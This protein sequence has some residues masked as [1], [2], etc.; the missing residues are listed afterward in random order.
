MSTYDEAPSVLGTAMQITDVTLALRET[1]LGEY[2]GDLEDAADDI[3]LRRI[4]AEAEPETRACLLLN[5]A[6]HSREH[7]VA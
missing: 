5:F 7:D 4:W 3:E 2:D 1:L 6:W